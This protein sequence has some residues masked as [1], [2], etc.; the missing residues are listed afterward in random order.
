LEPV[1][2]PKRIHS[3]KEL[4]LTKSFDGKKV[5]SVSVEKNNQSLLKV[6]DFSKNK[7]LVD[8]EKEL[9]EFEEKYKVSNVIFSPDGKKLLTRGL[10]NGKD[11][12]VSIWNI[13]TGKKLFSFNNDQAQSNTF[14]FNEGELIGI[15]NV[16]FDGQYIQNTFKILDASINKEKEVFIYK[17]KMR[18]LENKDPLT[19]PLVF[20]PD[21]KKIA[22]F[23]YVKYDSKSDEPE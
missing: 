1:P 2:A 3:G 5:V 17:A 23:N 15:G 13:N 20:S 21:G 7:D 12:L 16:T 14:A 22:S 10:K 6:W 19:I 8:E 9:F 18:F 4:L 11:I